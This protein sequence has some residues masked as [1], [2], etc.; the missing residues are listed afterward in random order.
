M[1]R[2]DEIPEDIRAAI[3]AMLWQ[4]VGAFGLH[5]VSVSAGEDHDGDPVIWVDADFE[6]KGEPIDPK[7][8]A[9]L[10]GKLHKGV[11]EMGETRFPH[12]RNHFSEDQ[13]IV[14]FA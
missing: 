3:N 6:A 2:K 11:W 10:V 9:A 14:G 13:K 1:A 4:E 8:F 7:A 5:K 12:L